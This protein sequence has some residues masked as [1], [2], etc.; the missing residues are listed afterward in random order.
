MGNRLPDIKSQMIENRV[1]NKGCTLIE[2][3]PVMTIVGILAAVAIPMYI[4]AP[5]KAKSAE[6]TNAIGYIVTSLKHL[7]S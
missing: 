2:L 7:S 3:L 5:I 1:G 4:D 6:V